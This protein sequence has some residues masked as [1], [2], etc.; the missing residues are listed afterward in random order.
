MLL[1]KIAETQA[2]DATG[3]TI[4]QL[5][6]RQTAEPLKPVVDPADWTA[7]D[8]AKAGDYIYRLT[9]SHIA[10]LD[11]AVKHVQANNIAIKDI[12]R[13]DFPL[14]TLDDLLAGIHDQLLDGRG[15]ALLKGVPVKRYTTEQAAIA[16]WGMGLHLGVP[17]SQNAKGHLLGHVKNL[18][19]DDFETETHRGYHTSTALPW[20]ADSCDVVGLM[21]LQTSKSGGASMVVSAAAIHNEMLKRR[22]DLVEE[23]A[24]PWHR[25]RRG[26]IPDG[27]EPWWS[28][29]VFNYVDG[30]LVTSWQ[31]KYIRA[32]QRFDELPRFTDAQTEAL[33]MITDLAEE[34]RFDMTF[35]RGDVQWVHNHVILHRR[36]AYEDYDEPERKRHLMRLWLATP[37]GRPVPQGLI[38]RYGALG[39]GGRPAGI[40]VKDMLLK[41][42]LEAE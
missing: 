9:D 15:I 6:K 28:L 34:L 11:Q 12:T 23:L 25:D 35:E 22:P 31:G 20:H 13:D 21:C 2:T 40:I 10:E 24:K 4:I 26:E 30:H 41:T 16:Y 17:V 32:A 3:D 19:G 33:E 39:P 1:A 27:K 38:E 18:S 7:N 5:I 42:P 14:P 29:P 37:N 8:L 36:T